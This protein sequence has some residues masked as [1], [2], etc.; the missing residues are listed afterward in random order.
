MTQE[1]GHENKVCSG[2]EIILS[3][4]LLTRD[5]PQF[6]LP[7]IK[8]ILSQTGAEFSL[9]VSDNSTNEE[10]KILI[11]EHYPDI[12]YIRR[13]REYTAKEHIET[14]LREVSTEYICF[15]HDDDQMTEN[16]VSKL[17]TNIQGKPEAVAIC[18]NAHLVLGDK[19]TEIA[20][21]KNSEI[22]SSV[23]Q[24][25]R[26][27]FKPGL[28]FQAPF[29]GY[30]YKTEILKNVKIK[31]VLVGKYNDLLMI[32]D[33]LPYGPIIWD[34]EAFILYRLHSG[35][36]SSV[37][38]IGNRLSLFETL[39][40]HYSPNNKKLFEACAC[41]HIL[42]YYFKSRLYPDAKG[43]GHKSFFLSAPALLQ[44]LFWDIIKHIR[45]MINV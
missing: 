44:M 4:I 5:R 39:G 29:P 2:V 33:L 25:T 41:Y 12:N 34:A 30:I 28:F 15:F 43:L 1:L 32:C 42:K 6:V 7:A 3:V 17:I 31:D 24:L 16:Y 23:D 19:I 35:N 18:G 36:D 37:D 13:V 27:Y 11:H 38:D 45:F 8:S 14:C 20:L 40:Q 26:L 22:I 21:I 9:I 10:T